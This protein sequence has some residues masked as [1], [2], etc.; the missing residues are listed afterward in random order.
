MFRSFFDSAVACQSAFAFVDNA[1]GRIVGSSRYN[2]YDPT[3]S[4][5]EIGWTF[6]TRAYWGGSHNA[7]VKGLMLGHA[8]TFVDTVVFWVGETNRRSQRA[9]GKIGGVRR[10]GLFTRTIRGV[11]DR[12]VVFEIQ[13]EQGEK[14]P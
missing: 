6:L 3:L 9:M 7:E 12:A 5:I 4:E 2:A 11:E 1:T 13:K 10:E 14:R 8:F